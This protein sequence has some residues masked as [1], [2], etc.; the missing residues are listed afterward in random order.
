MGD[1]DW[2]KLYIGLENKQGKP[3]KISKQWNNLKT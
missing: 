3:I 1:E 2:V